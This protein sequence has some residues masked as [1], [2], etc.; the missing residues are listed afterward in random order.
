MKF[1]LSFAVLV[2]LCFSSSYRASAEEVARC[3]AADYVLGSA[4]HNYIKISGH[5]YV[6]KCLRIPVGA[7][8][9]I[10]AGMVHPVQGILERGG[11][12]NPLVL[13]QGPSKKPVTERFTE[14]GI[15]GY[16]CDRHS[17]DTGN[18]M[19]GAIWVDGLN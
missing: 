9:T 17:D 19:A 10:D 8:V 13:K 5:K 2:G 18:K 16:Y 1:T 7:T 15:F 11:V 3:K 12:P 6:P 4:D 14:G